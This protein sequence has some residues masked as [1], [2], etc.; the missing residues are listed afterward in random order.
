MPKTDTDIR[1]ALVEIS[2]ELNFIVNELVETNQKLHVIVSN[3]PR[4]EK[5][6]NTKDGRV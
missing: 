3:M 2:R 5:E 4:E 6:E 1:S